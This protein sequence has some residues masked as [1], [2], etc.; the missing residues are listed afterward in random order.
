MTIQNTVIKNGYCIG[1]GACAVQSPAFSII[2]NQYGCYEAQKN[3][4]LEE[5]PEV[6]FVCP[7]SEEAKDETSIAKNLFEK[8]CSFD[9]KIG[10]YLSCYAGYAEEPF[11]SNGSS[12]G[13]TSWLCSELLNR[14]IIDGVIH[15]R[16]GED[17]SRLFEYGISYTPEELSKNTKSK[18]YPVELSKVLK[19]VAISDKK[20]ALIGVPCFIKA[21]RLLC[22]HNRELAEKI[23]YTI[24]LVCGHFKSKH[25][26]LSLAWDAGIHPSDLTSIDFR[27]S[28]GAKTASGYNTLF[29]YKGKDGQEKQLRKPTKEL[30][31]TNWGYGLFKY[32]ACDYCDD[33]IG[34]TADISIGDAW[35]PQ[36]V[37]DPKG[38]N[39]IVLRNNELQTF[40]KGSKDLFLDELSPEMAFYSQAGG[41]RHRR[42]GLAYRLYLKQE[43]NAWTPPKRT[44]PA[45]N[46]SEKRKSIYKLRE[47]IRKLCHTAFASAREKNSIAFFHHEMYDL[48]HLYEKLYRKSLIR[49]CLSKIKCIV[50]KGIRCITCR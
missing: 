12:G 30:F 50:S 7:F 47:D 15:A 18:Y 24:S 41:Y 34:E 26:A 17:P 13:I 1:C 14:K 32:K 42:E 31:G 35:L 19:E 43:K 44:K 9:K 8:T 11:R 22:E 33:V 5:P 2:E 25:Y 20:Y 40:L 21:V 39:V 48:L 6:S 36:Y 29:T 37:H 38:T 23:K 4:S 28:Q 3:D 16:E 45:A 27:D 49:K 10:Y 46:I